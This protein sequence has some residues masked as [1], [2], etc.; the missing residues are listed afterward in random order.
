MLTSTRK[1]FI[2]HT[3]KYYLNPDF[4][5]LPDLV[6]RELQIMC[7]LFT[8]DVGG[9]IILE[10]DEDGN[11]NLKTHCDEDDILYDEIGSVLIRYDGRDYITLPLIAADDVERSI[12]AYAFNCAKKLLKSPVS[13][14][15]LG[16][17]IIAI[18]CYI[19]YVIQYNK[20]K[21]RRRR[22]YY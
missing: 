12:I 10:Y 3:E 15:I 2:I 19:I 13:F 1:N 17:I 7:V 4:E 6:K 8:E 16:V 20:R 11:L 22:R 5:G 18:V 14:V 21:R 9:I